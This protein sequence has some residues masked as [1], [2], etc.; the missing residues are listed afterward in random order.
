MHTKGTLFKETPSN[1]SSSKQLNILSD[2]VYGLY[3]LI[4]FRAKTL[5]NRNYLN[6]AQLSKVHYNW[7]TYLILEQE[8]PHLPP[9][10]FLAILTCTHWSL[11]ALLR[12]SQAFKMQGKI[13]ALCNKFSQAMCS[14]RLYSIHVKCD[15]QDDVPQMTF[16]KHCLAFYK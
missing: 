16:M 9:L 11:Y 7:Q 2:I 6:S 5:I 1:P 12:L 13:N 14:M 3:S 8:Q 4:A 15:A 10:I